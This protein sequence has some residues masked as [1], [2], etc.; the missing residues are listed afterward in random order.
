MRLYTSSSRTSRNRTLL[1]AFAATLICICRSSAFGGQPASPVP[2]IQ[3][4][5][6]SAVAPQDAS[7]FTPSTGPVVPHNAGSNSGGKCN[8]HYPLVRAGGSGATSI[9]NP[10]TASTSAAGGYPLVRRG[11]SGEH[12]VRAAE[13]KED[14]AKKMARIRSGPH[15]V[16]PPAVGIHV[17]SGGSVSATNHTAYTVVA[18]F[19]GPSLFS[20]TIPAGGV[21]SSSMNPGEYQVSAQIPSNASILPFYTVQRFRPYQKYPFVFYIRSRR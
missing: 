20:L 21:R 11:A 17:S 4:P 2:A 16:L 19:V 10:Q 13:E 1:R 15:G 3:I 14:L 8:P 5:I 12:A 18:T 6:K 7:S 9:P